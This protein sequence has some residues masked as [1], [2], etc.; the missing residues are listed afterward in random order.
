MRQTALADAVAAVRGGGT[1]VSAAAAAE[2]AT[3]AV[4]APGGGAASQGKAAAVAAA[5]AGG[6]RASNQGVWRC[7][8]LSRH[9]HLHRAPP[10]GSRALVLPATDSARGGQGLED[11]RRHPPCLRCASASRSSVETRSRRTGSDGRG[12][13]DP[14]AAVTG[15]SR[16]SIKV[17]TGLF[18]V[19][20]KSL[21]RRRL[22]V[23][24]IPG[25]VPVEK[26]LERLDI[27]SKA[28]GARHQHSLRQPL[29][30]SLSP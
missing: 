24:L 2:R 16:I 3:S 23:S 6:K 1:A 26:F 27:S 15:T 11:G 25:V 8:S 30:I 28:C 9:L 21:R 29:A 7:E 18:L 19:R 17:S 12:I 13:V 5:A 22:T 4:S 14:G 10:E 20:V